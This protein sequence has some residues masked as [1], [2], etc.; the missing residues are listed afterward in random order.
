MVATWPFL[1]NKVKSWAS[2]SRRRRMT[3][4]IAPTTLVG[5]RCAACFVTSGLKRCSI[6]RAAFYCSIPCQRQDIARHRR[7]DGCGTSAMVA[8][9]TRAVAEPAKVVPGAMSAATSFRSSTSM[10]VSRGPCCLR[11][12]RPCLAGGAFY[13][14]IVRRSIYAAEGC[15]HGPLCGRCAQ[16]LRSQTLPFCPGC[17]ALV[18][19][20]GIDEQGNNEPR[21]AVLQSAPLPEQAELDALD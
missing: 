12:T 10:A 18:A 16:R 19:S 14:S 3:P 5:A 21:S 8:T 7:E 9:S 17:R 20:V 15:K 4:E 2:C 1:V 11:C 6:C 13:A